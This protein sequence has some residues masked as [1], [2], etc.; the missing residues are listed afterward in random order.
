MNFARFCRL[1]ASK[2]PEREFLIESYPSKKS[3]RVLTWKEL[4]EQTNKVANY[5]IKECGIKKGDVVQHLLLNSLEW[6]IT[7]MAVL[8]TGA[9]VSPLNFR[10]ASNDIKYA[11]DVT[12]SKVFIL[13]ETF[14]PRVEPIMK[15]MDYCKH[16]V[17]VGA[18]SPATMKLYN[19][20][21][22]NGRTSPVLVDTSDDD[23]AELMFTSGTTGAPKPVSHT[24]GTLFWIGIGNALTYNEGYNSV[25]LSPHPFYHSGTLFLSFPCYI[26]AGKILMP[27]ELTA[28]ELSEV[29]R[30]RAV[31]GR[32]EYGPHLG[33]SPHRHKVGPDQPQRL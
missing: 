23:G 15:E 30:R 3:R 31:Y 17:C 27:M 24:H 10:F 2:F 8:K 29:D 26:A 16:Y 14:V 13:G 7:Y 25:Y 5:L 32:L 11:C 12:K 20:I 4:E 21:I 9:V 18:T 22:E 33:R 1:N 28:G 6:Y 19:E